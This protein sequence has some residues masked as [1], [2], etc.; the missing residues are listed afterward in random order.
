MATSKSLA[1]R[2]EAAISAIVAALQIDATALH[3]D[4]AVADVELLE[5]IAAALQ[6]QQDAH[7]ET[8]G[9]GEAEASAD[10]AGAQRSRRK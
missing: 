7:A 6:V 3:K 8:R 5:R 2:R 1:I 10:L 9:R 4:A